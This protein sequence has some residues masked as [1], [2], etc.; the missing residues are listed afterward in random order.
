MLSRR[1]GLNPRSVYEYVG[2]VVGKLGGICCGQIGIGTCFFLFEY[3]GTFLSASFY[4][5]CLIIFFSCS[6]DVTLSY[7]LTAYFDKISLCVPEVKNSGVITRL[8]NAFSRRCLEL[9]RLMGYFYHHHRCHRRHHHHQLLIYIFL[10][11]N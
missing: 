11:F 3:F 10:N 1:P 2:C 7:H 9:H 6:T 8:P 5:S 4:K